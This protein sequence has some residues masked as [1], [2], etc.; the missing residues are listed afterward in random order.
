[1]YGI[2]IKVYEMV[3]I[4]FVIKFLKEKKLIKINLL[5]DERL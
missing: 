2:Y 4:S 3:N 5:K 1:M